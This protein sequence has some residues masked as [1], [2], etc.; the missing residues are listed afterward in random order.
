[1]GQTP[2]EIMDRAGIERDPKS[3]QAVLFDRARDPELRHQ[4]ALALA[5]LEDRASVPALIKAIDESEPRARQG[6]M[7]ALM[8]LPSIDAVP[9]LC[10]VVHSDW[11]RDSHGFAIIALSQIES[12]AAT[13]CIVDAAANENETIQARRQ[14]LF[15]LWEVKKDVESVDGLIPLLKNP[16]TTL[17]ALAA[18][19]LNRSYYQ[20]KTIHESLKITDA[21]VSSALDPELYMGNFFDVVKA[22]EVLSGQPFID[23]S[24][25]PE[26]GKEFLKYFDENRFLVTEDVRTWSES[27]ER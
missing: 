19:C 21:L 11:D 24:I 25:R 15:L 2:L 14:A 12:H 6:A 8:Y 26:A 27:R 22:L 17:R 20:S 4:S 13:Q 18:L 10:D 5:Q 1:M 9:K 23:A 3:I 7:A 16:N